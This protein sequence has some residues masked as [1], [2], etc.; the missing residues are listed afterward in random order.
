VNLG[1]LAALL[2][3]GALIFPAITQSAE[4]AVTEQESHEIG[5]QA[6][7]TFIR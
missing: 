5:V 1:I 2:A 3:L 4:A 7:C 6:M